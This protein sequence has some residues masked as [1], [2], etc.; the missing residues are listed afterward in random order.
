MKAAMS[1]WK[2]KAQGI[3]YTSDTI[4]THAHTH[5]YIQEARITATTNAAVSPWKGKAQGIIQV[6]PKEKSTAPARRR[7]SLFLTT[8][9]HAWTVMTATMLRA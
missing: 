8:Q 3:D 9:V 2:G 5:T 7:A 4:Y 1:A 6:T